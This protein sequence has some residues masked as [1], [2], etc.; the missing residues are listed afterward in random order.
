M[1]RVGTRSESGRSRKRDGLLLAG[2][3]LGALLLRA[4]V[5]LA[6][7]DRDPARSVE[8]DSQS[9]ED[10]ARALLHLGRFA[11][12][13]ELADVPQTVRTPGYPAFIAAVYAIF[14]EKHP[15][16]ILT[17]IL[18][19]VATLG[20]VYLIGCR[21]WS[22]A[23]AL[24]SVLILV[25]DHTTFVYSQVF[26]TETLFTFALVVTVWIGVRLA[27]AERRGRWWALSLGL[28]LAVQALIR[29]IGYYLVFLV[30]LA[31]LL[32]GIVARWKRNELA[33]ILLLVSL[34]WALLV[35]GWQVRNWLATG[36]SE[37]SSIQSF[38]LLYYRGACIVAK[39]DDISFDSARQVIDA[40]LGDTDG[41][42]EAQLGELYMQ[43][44]VELI[45]RNPLLSLEC[46]LIGGARMLLPPGEGRLVRY[47]GIPDAREKTLED[48]V[49]LSLSEYKQKWLV[50]YPVQFLVFI[51]AAL[52]LYSLYGF[53]AAGVWHS[54]ARDRSQR[55]AHLLALGVILYFM[56][57][58]AG[59]EAYAR[60]RM[61]IMPFLALYAGL[62]VTLLTDRLGAR[63]ARAARPT[64]GSYAGGA[65]GSGGGIQDSLEEEG[66]G[67]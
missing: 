7:F 33:M 50:E 65:A 8:G 54:L 11:V 28:G 61:P 58:S 14:G 27:N 12:S 34:P 52:Y 30:L 4:L 67:G 62:G 20:F 45:R 17:Q 56:V 35:G 2:I 5:Y 16:V 42:P 60:F 26:L 9:Y 66:N 10:S 55:F 24:V 64:G 39:R 13:P 29:P 40:T 37:F 63:G 46:Q 36:S 6:V 43:E 31:F 59:P 41:M 3:L 19:S 22:S 1:G 23:A 53:A 47:L 21:F 38:N 48:L 32:A 49:R 44:G 57:V 15:P 25:L 18:L 51:P